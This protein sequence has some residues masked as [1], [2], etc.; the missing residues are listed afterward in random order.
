MN[1]ENRIASLYGIPRHL[2][3]AEQHRSD[4]QLGGQRKNVHGS[5]QITAGSI[6]DTTSTALARA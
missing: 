1:R 4:Y 3:R 5:S 2:L 6:A